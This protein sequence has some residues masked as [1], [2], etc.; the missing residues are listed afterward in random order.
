MKQAEVGRF[1][2]Q[3]QGCVLI[4]P[5]Q[6]VLAPRPRQ[7]IVR[8]PVRH[9]ERDFAVAKVVRERDLGLKTTGIRATSE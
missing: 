3:R 9:V 2:R 1:R 6:R 4:Q 8:T 5:P 7:L